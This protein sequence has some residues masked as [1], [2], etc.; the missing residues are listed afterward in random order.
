MIEILSP[1]TTSNFNP[2]REQIIHVNGNLC[3]LR[4]SDDIPIFDCFIPSLILGN[5]TKAEDWISRL[6]NVGTTHININLSGDYNENLG[7]APRYPINGYDFTDDLNLLK[8]CMNWLL[9]YKMIPHLHLAC[10]GQGYDPNGWTYGFSWGM[11]NIPVILDKL[12]E[13]T[14][15]ILWNA[16]YDGCFPNWSP[17]QFNTFYQMLRSVLGNEAQLAAEFAGTGTIGYIDLGNGAASWQIDAPCDVLDVFCTELQEWPLSET[18][19]VQQVAARLLG[20]QA[21]NIESQNWMAGRPPSD[22]NCYIPINRTRGKLGVCYYET[23]AYWAI[24]KQATPSD[25]V[26]SARIGANYGFSDFGNGLP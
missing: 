17:A 4:D 15:K 9:S 8:D 22:S 19:G 24:R 6:I 2:T 20:S 7:W 13:F 25:A 10:D 12:S 26:A 3:N 16:G 5:I 23:L 11:D 21:K 18:N 1:S 14:K